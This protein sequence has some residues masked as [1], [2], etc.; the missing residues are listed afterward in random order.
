MI[1]IVINNTKCF[2]GAQVGPTTAIADAY[3][4]SA[5]SWNA[6]ATSTQGT[7]ADNALPK[8]GGTM[9]GAIAMGNSNITGVNIFCFA[10]PGPTEGIHWTGGNTKIVESPDNLTT[11]SAGNLQMVYGSTR[12][13]TVN[14]TGIDVNGNIVVSGTVD[15]RNVASMTVLN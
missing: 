14:N 13:L 10:D 9:T 1:A 3:I 2:I 4:A 11:N 8:A 7:K 15:G 5:S 6:C 12:R